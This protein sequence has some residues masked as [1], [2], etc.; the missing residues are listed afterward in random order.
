MTCA[1]AQYIRRGIPTLLKATPAWARLIRDLIEFDG[2]LDDITVEEW[3][4]R[5]R[6]PA[7]VRRIMLESMVIGLLNELPRLD[8]RACVRGSVADRRRPGAPDGQ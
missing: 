2:S 7:E 3:L 5:L 4:D 1:P 8:F 6:F